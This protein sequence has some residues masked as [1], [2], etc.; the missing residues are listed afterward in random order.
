MSTHM[1]DDRSDDTSVGLPPTTYGGRTQGMASESDSVAFDEQRQIDRFGGINWGAGFFGWLVAV[2]V[3]VLLAGIVGAAA[4]A[5]GADVGLI[6]SQAEANVQ[7]TGLLAGA[8]LL[9]VLMVGYYAGGYVAGRM[10]RFHGG[11]Q[12]FAAWLIGVVVTVAAVTVG[13][14]LGADYNFQQA[15][16]GQPV[17][18][19]TLTQ[20]GVALGVLVLIGTLIAAMAGGKVG[21]RYHIKVDRAAYDY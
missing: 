12:G 16:P 19:G 5:A 13:V 10:S 8:A 15:L 2:G 11:R 6:K 1:T 18:Q 9:L 7:R 17:P 14:L 4:K 20:A 21:R 3:S